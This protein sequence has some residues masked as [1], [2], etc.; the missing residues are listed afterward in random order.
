MNHWPFKIVAT[1]KHSAAIMAMPAASPSMLSMKFTALTMTT[2]QITVMTMLS[3]SP[4]PPPRNDASRRTSEKSTVPM[5]TANCRI[6]FGHAES[7]RR[8]S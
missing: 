2:I 4:P 6:N 1:M 5:A 7:A 8:S 3:T